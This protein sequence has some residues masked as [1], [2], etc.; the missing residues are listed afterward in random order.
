MMKKRKKNRKNKKDRR[1]KNEPFP[2]QVAVYSDSNVVASNSW[3]S[4]VKE[5][6]LWIQHS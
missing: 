1:D 5:A 4:P 3:L 6:T 2:H